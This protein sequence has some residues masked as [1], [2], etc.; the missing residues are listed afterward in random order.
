MGVRRGLWLI[1]LTFGFAEFVTSIQRQQYA[2]NLFSVTR[3]RPGS[4][5]G[6]LD[7]TE[8][9]RLFFIWKETLS[10]SFIRKTNAVI[11]NTFR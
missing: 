2:L 6:A 5:I 8:R 10:Y 1:V 4:I 7:F 3:L 11:M 9:V